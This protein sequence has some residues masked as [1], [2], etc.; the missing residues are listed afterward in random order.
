VRG[1]FAYGAFAEAH[2]EHVRFVAVAEPDPERRARFAARHHL[3]PER[4]YESWGDLIAAGQLAPALVCCT[5]DRLHVA[6]TVAALEAGYHVLLE[7]PIAVTPDDCVRVVQASERV[8]RLLMICHVLRY[9]PFFSA[10]HE[11]LHSGRLGEIVTIEHRENVAYWHMAHSFVRGNWGNA[12]R[13][14]PMILAKCCHDLDILQWM[15][16]GQPVKRLHSFGSLLHFQPDNAPPGAPVRCTDGCPVA[17]ECAF[18]APRLYLTEDVDWPTSAISTDL[19]YEGRLRALQTGPYGRCVY[20]CDN[21]VVDHQVVNME[22][23]TGAITTL[24]MHGHSHQ[25]G[26][27]MRYDGTRATLRGRYGDAGEADLTIH[28]HRTAG[29]ETVPLS[30]GAGGHGGGDAGVMRAFV[31]AVR[32]ADSGALSSVRASLESHLLAFAAERSR[33]TGAT[34]DMAAYRAEVE[35]RGAASAWRP[36]YT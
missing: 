17:D 27:T 7:K 35:S 34:V 19:S 26:R 22:H 15:M 3:P 9:T 24:V 4:C 10:L 36:H 2:P 25:E 1:T 5:M 8:H 11:I 32:G 28:N 21:D 30:D 23:E 12:G 13:S 20:H 6:P 14:S 31:R 33:V 16:H 18:Y 29:V